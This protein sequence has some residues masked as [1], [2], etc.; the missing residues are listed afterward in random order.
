MKFSWKLINIFINLE[1]IQLNKFEEELTLSGIEIE[2]ISYIEEIKDNIFDLSIT[3]NRKEICSILSLAKEIGIIFN[4]PL[5]ILPINF[6][7]AK[8]QEQTIKKNYNKFIYISINKIS[9]LKIV[10]TPKWLT[11]CLK[12]HNIKPTN[13]INNIKQYIELKWGMKF[14]IFNIKDLSNINNLLN[15]DISLKHIE[16]NKNSKDH[17]LIIFISNTNLN[18]NTINTVN[19]HEE[20][21]FNAYIDTMKLLST[22]TSCVYGK[23]YYEYKVKQPYFDIITIS[24]NE[25]NTVLGQTGNNRFS[26]LSSISIVNKLKQLNLS[27]KYNKFLQTFSIKVPP[28]RKHDLQRKIDIIEEIGRINGFNHFVDKLPLSKRKGII[29]NISIKIKNLRNILRNLG[30]NEVV[31]CCLINNYLKLNNYNIKVYN[32]ITQEQTELRNNITEKLIEN[33]ISNIKQNN[34]TV[35][36]FEIGKTFHKDLHNNYIE[37]ISLGGLIHNNKFVKSDW[38]DTPKYANFFHV[39]GIIE[40]VLEKLKAEVTFKKIDYKPNINYS[41]NIEELFNSKQKIGIY[42]P[43]NTE[44]VGILG[45]INPRYNKELNTTKYKIYLFEINITKLKKTIKPNDHLSYISK[46]YSNYPSVTRD[47]SI[48]LTKN[49]EVKEIKNALREK[50][51]ALIESIE[52]F[53]EYFNKKYK[54]KSIAIRIIYRSQNKTLDSNDIKK[55]DDHIDN[56]LLHFKSKT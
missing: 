41:K 39:K 29:S 16:L 20:Y 54:H 48:K 2:K 17:Q 35:E 5:K 12:T 6:F 47:I 25:I 28:N 51:N 19:V 23:S 44:L 37:N 26:Q 38:S 53:N 52:I 9:N 15:V 21:Y 30:F 11:N 32:P 33:C 36:L 43:Q 46:P 50:Q 4:K 49:T 55:I 22:L 56:V 31:N 3:T 18:K 27:P 24:K 8:I 1:S 7:N 10:H 34:D 42:N 13:T 40:I 45:E 14:Y